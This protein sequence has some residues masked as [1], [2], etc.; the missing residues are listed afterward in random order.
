MTCEQAWEAISAALDGELSDMERKELDAHLASCPA[1]R[2]LY[3]DWK[4]I[5][6]DTLDCELEVPEGF[7][8]RVM[9]GVAAAPEITPTRKKRGW[10]RW[11]GLAAVV[12]VAVLAVSP[13]LF[14]IG[15]D[16]SSSMQMTTEA[17]MDN[18]AA[19]GDVA[20]QDLQ[21]GAARTTVEEAA[22]AEEA[23][24][25]SE[26]SQGTDTSVA[27]SAQD[28]ATYWAVVTVDGP[29]PEGYTWGENGTL[30]LF[31][32]AW[33]VLETE[34]DRT[35]IAYEVRKTEGAT[36]GDSLVLVLVVQGDKR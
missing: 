9:E 12:A 35:G 34:L 14:S 3:E 10:V 16:D 30:E 33:S 31:R 29:L 36:D 4:G 20:L 5:R 7:Y 13:L 22:P 6:A 26:P 32:E 27:A 21:E 15:S 8:E 1:C 28:D 19:S 2:A 18:G 25:D 23:L 11:G 24:E 17:A